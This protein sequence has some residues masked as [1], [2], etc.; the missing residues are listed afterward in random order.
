M[1]DDEAR[2]VVQE[3]D[4]VRLK[5]SAEQQERAHQ[6]SVAILS[7]WLG[8]KGKRE[9]AAELSL[10]PLRVWQLSQMALSGMLAGLLKQP[11]WRGKEAVMAGANGGSER[12]VLTLRK[13][14]AVLKQRLE[15]Q[16]RLISLLS[17][18]NRSPRPP[19][20]ADKEEPASKDAL[21]A[22]KRGRPKKPGHEDRVVAEGKGPAEAR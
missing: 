3:D 20:E 1:A 16:E 4:Q 13:E 14:N 9:V 18:F 17:V 12:E 2:K 7:M 15:E 11:K 19:R 21:P 10:P 6:Q 22:R 8:R 5:A